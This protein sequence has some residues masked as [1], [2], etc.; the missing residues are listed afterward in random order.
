MRTLILIILLFV[1]KVGFTQ[2]ELMDILLD[3]VVIDFTIK[4]DPID[5]VYYEDGKIQKIFYGSQKQKRLY[6][7][8]GDEYNK[9]DCDQ[10]QY[11]KSGK[12]KLIRVN[13]SSRTWFENGNLQS[14]YR[15]INHHVNKISE[16]YEN[17]QIKEKGTMVWGH[18]KEKNEGEWTKSDDWKYWNDKGELKSNNH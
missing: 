3:S 9:I 10:K 16:W 8:R 11:Y 1:S 14:E 6:E 4:A 17:G 2:N 15:L 18:N 12:I 13:Q 5:T 7:V